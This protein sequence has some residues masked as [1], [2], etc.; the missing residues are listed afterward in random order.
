[1]KISGL[2]VFISFCSTNGAD[3]IG[4]FNFFFDR[5]IIFFLFFCNTN[6]V[7]YLIEMEFEHLQIFLQTFIYK[8][9]MNELL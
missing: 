7:W 9:I 1:M 6:F 5:L 2:P 4:F 8:L 3:T